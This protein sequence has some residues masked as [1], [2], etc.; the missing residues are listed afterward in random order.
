MNCNSAFCWN[1]SSK[2][3]AVG[4]T[5]FYI[6]FRVYSISRDLM[7]SPAKAAV[8]KQG[9][10]LLEESNRCLFTD[11]SDEKLGYGWGSFFIPQVTFDSEKCPMSYP[12][13][14]A[15]RNNTLH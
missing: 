4:T 1:S 6:V 9:K 2:K 12:S 14:K 11:R 8:N 10:F 15:R 3:Q 13:Q 5:W 7:V